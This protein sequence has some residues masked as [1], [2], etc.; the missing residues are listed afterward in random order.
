VNAIYRIAFVVTALAASV[1]GHAA[2]PS[3]RLTDVADEPG[4]I[5][6][7]E[8][9]H[10]VVVTIKAIHR[11][12]TRNYNEENFGL[13]LER[14]Y[15][16]VWTVGAGF[17]KN[18]YSRDTLYALAYYTPWT[19]KKD[20]RVGVVFGVVSG[21]DEGRLSP[22]LTGVIRRDFDNRLGVNIYVATSAVAF[23]VRWA[24]DPV[25]PSR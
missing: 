1:S 11:N 3:L 4:L 2:E 8:Y 19:I 23:Q 25:D 18:S 24:L 22:W 9:R 5:L 10:H 21:Y 13:G 6:P 12:R 15:S 14:Q 17:Y 16:L 7:T 20:W